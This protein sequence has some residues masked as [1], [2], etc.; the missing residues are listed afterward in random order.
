MVNHNGGHID[1]TSDDIQRIQI[2]MQH[3]FSIDLGGEQ[4][5]SSEVNVALL[6]TSLTTI[7]G[8]LSLAV[9]TSPLWSPLAWTMIGGLLITTLLTLVVAPYCAKLICIDNVMKRFQE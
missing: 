7:V 6:L 4:A 9:S 8:M 3:G 1:I 5:E 2:A